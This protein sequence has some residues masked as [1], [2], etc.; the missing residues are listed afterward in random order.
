[1]PLTGVVY[2]TISNNI[3]NEATYSVTFQTCSARDFDIAY[4]ALN[5]T[6]GSCSLPKYDIVMSM[7]CDRTDIDQLPRKAMIWEK[8][9]Q[10]SVRTRNASATAIGMR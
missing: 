4:N 3:I 6:T 5:E 10:G 8:E 9:L 1:M 7:S 2:A